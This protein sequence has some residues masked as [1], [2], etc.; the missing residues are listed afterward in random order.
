[1]SR[2][3]ELAGFSERERCSLWIVAGFVLFLLAL[4]AL[5]GGEWY[6]NHY[7][8][9]FPRR[10]TGKIVSSPRVEF[11]GLVWIVSIGIVVVSALFSAIGWIR[12]PRTW[13]C[14]LPAAPGL[15]LVGGPLTLAAVGKTIEDLRRLFS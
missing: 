14:L 6:A 2:M 9:D 8:P 1:M 3:Q 10:D 15:L 7:V 13:R 4:A 11:A 12:G 5:F